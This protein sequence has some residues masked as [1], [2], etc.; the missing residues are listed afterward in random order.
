MCIAASS[1]AAISFMAGWCVVVSKFNKIKQAQ[2]KESKRLGLLIKS[3]VRLSI[4]SS[5]Y[6]SD[7]RLANDGSMTRSGN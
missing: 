3:G 7:S 5:S 2:F 4:G 1:Q 6:S